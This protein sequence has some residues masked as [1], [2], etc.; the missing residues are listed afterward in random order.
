MA[1][2]KWTP[3]EVEVLRETYPF[4]P[5]LAIAQ[6]LKLRERQVFHKAKSL[7]LYKSEIY[8][9]TCIAGRIQ[10]GERGRETRFQPGLVPWNKGCHFVAGGRSAETR[11][12]KGCRH[13]VAAMI[14]QPIGTERISK[15]GYLERKIND[16]MPFRKRWRAV[17]ILNWEAVHGPLP[18]GH[19]L[20]FRDGDKRNTAVDNLE[21][22]TRAELMRRNTL[23][24]Y[25]KE[26][27]LLI[28]L[29]GQITRQLNKRERKAA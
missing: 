7:G 10:K 1:K 3:L 5:T 9:Q 24:R 19:A 22:I 25:P 28:Q 23:H 14:Y 18:K 6:A 26:I 11:F 12:K 17:H 8:L 29:K 20:V 27:A 4:Y 21:L 16:G 15:D 2:H 13:G